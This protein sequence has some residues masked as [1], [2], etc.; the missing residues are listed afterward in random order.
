VV[1]LS[2]GLEKTTATA[3]LLRSGLVRGLIIDGDS[4][5]RLESLL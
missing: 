5:A 1:L 4:A 2:A 3:A